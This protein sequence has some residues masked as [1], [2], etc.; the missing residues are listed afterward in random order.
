[1]RPCTRHMS[2]PTRSHA[3]VRGLASAAFFGL[4]IVGLLAGCGKGGGGG[5]GSSAQEEKINEIVVPPAPDA[6]ANAATVNGVDS[7]KNGIRDDVDRMLASEFGTNAQNYT[8]ATTYAKTQQAAITAPT[9]ATISQHL[10]LVRC[11]D[12]DKKLDDFKKITTATIDTSERRAAYGQAF[13]G[14]VIS[15]EGCAK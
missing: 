1:M 7:D 5:G 14:A 11:I 2:L 15:S 8:A 9:E 4:L 12:D 10:S 13:A 3:R 6:T